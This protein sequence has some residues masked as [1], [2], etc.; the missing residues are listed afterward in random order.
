M[1]RVEGAPTLVLVPGLDGTALM[2]YRQ[3]SLLAKRFNVVAFPLPDDSSMDM[4]DLIE[5]LA[6]LLDE[7]AGPEVL[8][9]G[10]SFGGALS[11]SFALAHPERLRGLVIVNSFSV[12]HQ[13]AKLLLG[14]WLLRAMP[15]GAMP[16]M[17]RFTEA[18]LHSP[19]AEPEDLREFRE[20]SK[21]IGKAGYLQRLR[22][23]QRYDVR[24]ALEDLRPPAL[25][26][27]GDR[28]RLVPS[29]SEARF[30]ADRAPRGTVKILE[31]YGHICMINHDLDLLEYI[32]PWYDAHCAVGRKGGRMTRLIPP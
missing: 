23:L 28:D 31:G 18:K 32:E 29:V 7:V 6:T 13:R 8:L 26:L 10:E 21:Q 9:C 3:V 15:W 1:E 17:R 16:L 4:A 22:I 25:F 24:E 2:F 14:P 19:H 20:R 12:V 11:L 27:A 5:D 30:M